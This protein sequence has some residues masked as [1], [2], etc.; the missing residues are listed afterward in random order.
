[1]STQY[2]YV[3]I[4]QFSDNKLSAIVGQKIASCGMFD[5]HPEFDNKNNEL[6]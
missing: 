1:M 4:Q 6:F 5:L 3:L 2:N